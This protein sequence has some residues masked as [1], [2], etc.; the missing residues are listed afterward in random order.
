[1]TASS[2]FDS[3]LLSPA[4]VKRAVNAQPKLTAAELD[5]H[6]Q[7]AEVRL[8]DTWEG[9]FVKYGNSNADEHDE[10]DVDTGK[11]VVDRGVLSGAFA[12]PFGGAAEANAKGLD[13]AQPEEQIEDGL[14]GLDGE[15]DEDEEDDEDD[16]PENTDADADANVLSR[17]ADIKKRIMAVPPLTLES[18]RSGT[19]KLPVPLRS[20]K[21]LPPTVLQKKAQSRPINP[22]VLHK[23][24]TTTQIAHT[25]TSN[26][27]K[28]PST[29]PLIRSEK[30]SIG[31]SPI[32]KPSSAVGTNL[33]KPVRQPPPIPSSTTTHANVSQSK[34]SHN[35]ARF[36]TSNILVHSLSP[37][38]PRA[39]EPKQK[40]PPT[41]LIRSATSSQPPSVISRPPIVS[42]SN[43][44]PISASSRIPSATN[45]KPPVIPSR[46]SATLSMPIAAASSSISMQKSTPVTAKPVVATSK[47]D[48]T[49]VL[50]ALKPTNEFSSPI[51]RLTN[52][53]KEAPKT[54]LMQNSATP[55]SYSSNFAGVVCIPLNRTPSSILDSK[56]DQRNSPLNS[57]LTSVK[58]T[59]LTKKSPG[60]SYLSNTS[61]SAIIKAVH[62]SSSRAS[63]SYNTMDS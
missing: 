31:P 23:T 25:S 36:P 50:R 61:H 44:T 17:L 27:L 15:D 43:N 54:K 18:L 12:R 47:S 9:I 30:P 60:V 8:R 24:P 52:T 13:G 55:K 34:L 20:D 29:K 6:R 37:S 16:D 3:L 14:D 48:V 59:V 19:E 49:P 62:T 22:V 7:Q 4:P 45:S 38:I 39:T 56:P 58:K 53:A 21:V 40:L 11:I 2:V 1:M 63:S 33:V 46:T 42:S 35:H 26:S 51:D 5:L 32:T 41:H 10:I 57:K 28:V